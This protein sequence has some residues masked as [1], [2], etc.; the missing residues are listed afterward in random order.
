MMYVKI[1]NQQPPTSV[2]KWDVIFAKIDH[3]E[4]GQ[5]SKG[6][7]LMLKLGDTRIDNIHIDRDDAAKPNNIIDTIE[8]RLI[9]ITAGEKSASDGIT[10]IRS[11]SGPVICIDSIVPWFIF[12]NKYGKDWCDDDKG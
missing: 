4:Y 3:I 5:F 2:A 10:F 11:L 8:R 9:D 7:D 1:Y 12:I 6:V